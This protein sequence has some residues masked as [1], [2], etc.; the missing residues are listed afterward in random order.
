MTT[1]KNSELNNNSDKLVI[2]EM[3]EAKYVACN[4]VEQGNIKANV[5]EI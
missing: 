1:K 5:E 4:L 3:Q 2:S